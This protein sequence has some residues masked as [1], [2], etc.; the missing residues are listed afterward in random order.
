MVLNVKHTKNIEGEGSNTRDNSGEGVNRFDGSE[1]SEGGQGIT[2]VSLGFLDPC[3][4]ALGST[5]SA[6][7]G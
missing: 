7:H 1:V 3:K 4:L 2:D 5:L 6:S